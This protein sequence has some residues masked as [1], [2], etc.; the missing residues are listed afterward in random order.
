VARAG[1][2][3]GGLAMAGALSTSSPLAT[4]AAFG[5][6]GLGIG[7]LIPA[8]MR[9]ADALPG[10]PPGA[11]LTVVGT[12]DRVAIFAAPPVIGAVADAA[13]LRVGLLA[14]PLAMVLVVLV[15]AALPRRVGP[16]PA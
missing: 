3:L 6:I 1:A 2:G 9:S 15:A 16:A 12:I 4:V 11:G 10:L 7:T 5:V 14:M 8:S 13:G